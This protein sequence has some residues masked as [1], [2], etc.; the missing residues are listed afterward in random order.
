M[1]STHKFGKPVAPDTYFYIIPALR[2]GAL[3]QHWRL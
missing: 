2:A 1:I 3:W